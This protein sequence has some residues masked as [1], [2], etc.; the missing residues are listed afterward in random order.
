MDTPD[1]YALLGVAQDADVETIRRAYKAKAFACHPDVNPDD[2]EAAAKFAALHEAFALLADP[3]RRADLD[4]LRLMQGVL[5]GAW[6][7]RRA[8]QT[9]NDAFFV[10]PPPRPPRRGADIRRN[11][12]IAPALARRGGRYS[13]E[14]RM[15]GVCPDCGGTGY[16]TRACWVCNGRGSIHDR[17]GALVLPMACPACG[18][19]GIEKAPCPGCLG[20]GERF[21]PHRLVVDVAPGTA[22]GDV[23]LVPGGGGPGQGGAPAGDMLLVARVLPEKI[24]ET[25]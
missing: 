14:V 4:R 8:G 2:G 23:L 10:P 3:R 22:T 5:S 9:G 12:D 13:F 25:V 7:L 11:F 6:A 18:G 24:G 17:A 19:V 20:L 21:G 16:E 1:P 15:F